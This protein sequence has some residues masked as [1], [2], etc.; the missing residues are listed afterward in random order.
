VVL[1]GIV[2]LVTWQY[3]HLGNKKIKF[4]TTLDKFVKKC[5]LHE[6]KFKVGQN[7]IHLIISFFIPNF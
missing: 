6:F 3:L 7:I 1:F 5:Y 4:R 2:D